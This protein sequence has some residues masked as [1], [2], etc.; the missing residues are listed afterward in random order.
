MHAP[1]ARTRAL[2]ASGYATGL[3]QLRLRRAISAAALAREARRGFGPA[4]M[5]RLALAQPRA[6]TTAAVE[7]VEEGTTALPRK[8]PRPGFGPAGQP[9]SRSLSRGSRA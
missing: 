3:D 9:A 4:E 2:H 8:R 5:A 7:E 1:R 6:R